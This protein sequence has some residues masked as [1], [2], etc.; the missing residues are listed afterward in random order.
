MPVVDILAEAKF[1]EATAQICMRPDLQARYEAEQAASHREDMRLGMPSN[2]L[3]LDDLAAQ[4][5]EATLTFHLRGISSSEYNVLQRTAGKPRK[6]VKVD[7]TIGFNLEEFHIAVIK[8]CTV[9]VTAPDGDEALFD[10][11]QWQTF[12]AHITDAQ[13]DTLAGAA[14][15]V[16]RREPRPPSRQPTF[17]TP[18]LY[19]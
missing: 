6:D 18:T 1:P 13:F 16:N 11:E 5:A 9:K 17:A 3:L 15:Q 12:F 2:E 4:M 10:G 14:T 7:A 19:G 8:R